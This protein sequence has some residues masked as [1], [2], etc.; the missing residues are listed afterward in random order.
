MHNAVIEVRDAREEDRG[1]FIDVL[2]AA[3]VQYAD[4]LP[5]GRWETYRASLRAS[6]DEGRPIARIVA[7]LEGR[8]LGSLQLFGSSEEAYGMPELNIRNPVFRYLA[9]APEARGRGVA[10]LLIR[11]AIR[12][13]KTLGGDRLNLHTTDVMQDAIRL[14]ERLG[15]ERAPETDMT[16]GEA[17]VKGYRLELNEAALRI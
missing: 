2:L 1:G 11:E 3:Y 15:F 8:I 12:R 5:A 4:V 16:G 17:I 9:V 13:A 7:V 6:F 10:T 14:Y